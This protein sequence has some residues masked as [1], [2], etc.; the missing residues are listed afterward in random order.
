MSSS[1]S[2]SER[3]KNSIFLKMSQHFCH[4]CH[5]SS[6][7]LS[8]KNISINIFTMPFSTSHQTGCS[9][10]QLTELQIQSNRLSFSSHTETWQKE[11]PPQEKPVE[12]KTRRLVSIIRQSWRTF[13][14]VCYQT[15]SPPPERYLRW[16]RLV[17]TQHAT[18]THSFDKNTWIV[19]FVSWCIPT[20]KPV[21]LCRIS[22]LLKCVLFPK[23]KIRSSHLPTG[24]LG[25]TGYIL[26][27]A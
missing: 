2:R 13:I 17:M 26:I 15:E 21:P 18:H 4:K 23:V 24:S 7:N 25:G 16:I 14:G 8:F 27:A 11:L 3:K 20:P 1:N 22:A 5:F 6:C 9:S 12:I 10:R 19:T